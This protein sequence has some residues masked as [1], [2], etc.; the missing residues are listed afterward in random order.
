MAQSM[1]SSGYAQEL[2]TKLSEFGLLHPH[3]TLNSVTTCVIAR[4]CCDTIQTHS[5]GN[6]TN[7]RTGLHTLSDRTEG[8]AAQPQDN[9]V[10]VSIGCGSLFG[11]EQKLVNAR[12]QVG[13]SD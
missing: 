1:I 4:H 7:K 12:H 2:G 9:P 8:H 6:C 11:V 5:I 3:I 10:N 13:P